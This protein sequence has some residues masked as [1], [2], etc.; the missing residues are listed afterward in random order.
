MGC[1]MVSYFVFL[2]CLILLLLL[3]FV[4]R[5]KAFLVVVFLTLFSGLRYG[6]GTDYFTYRKIFLRSRFIDYARSPYEIGF[7]FLNK[8]IR[9]LTEQPVW[10]FI[11]CA[12]LTA[13]F[14]VM[15][16]SQLNKVFG[17]NF[18]VSV[19]CYVLLGQY[20][21]SFNITR[22]SL[23][24]AIILFAFTKFA[25]NRKSTSVILVLLA[26]TIHS[27]ALIV[28]PFILLSRLKN[29]LFYS[30]V[31]AFAVLSLFSYERILSLVSSF[32]PIYSGYVGTRYT[33]SG[34]NVLNV[35][36]F[37]VL[38]FS[39]FVFNRSLFDEEGMGL[40][41]RLLLVG[42]VFSMMSLFGLA[43]ARIANYFWIAS[44]VVVPRFLD[45]FNKEEK[46]ITYLI[47]I[48]TMIMYMTLYVSNYGDLIPYTTVFGL[49]F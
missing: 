43:F 46:P 23:A 15:S 29:S 41:M 28:L 11:I 45:G 27:T 13:L 4:L 2:I 34:A 37:I 8:V 17:L 40:F 47:V 36:P 6:I 7:L 1:N 10:L 39:V 5:R 19:F 12:F 48:A 21:A 31:S 25:Q 38:T 26:S 44:V 20:F 49:V 22:Q 14:V 33:I 3:P 16:L 9:S 18:E 35:I 30:L 32:L 42:S 24:G